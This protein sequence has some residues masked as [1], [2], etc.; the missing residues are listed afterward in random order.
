MTDFAF[1]V[2]GNRFKCAD[3]KF[4]YHP[5]PREDELLS[6]WLVRTSL[7]HQTDPTTFI[8]LYLPEWRNILWTRDIDISADKKFLDTLVVKTGVVYETCHNLTLMSYEGYLAEEITTKTRNHF[9]QPLGNQSRIKVKHGLRFC[10]KC[11]QEDESPYFR[12]KWRLSFSTACIKH[13]CFLMDRCAGCG[14]A[15]N[16]HRCIRIHNLGISHCYN[17]GADF[18]EAEPEYIQ[19]GSY[20]LWAIRRLYEILDTGLFT[21][22]DGYT[23]SFLFFDVLQ[24][25]VRIVYYWGKTRG[26]LDHEEMSKV[27]DFREQRLRNNLIENIPLKEQYLLFSGLMR[28]FEGYPGRLLSFC[29]ANRLRGS[30]MTRDMKYIPLWH[31]KIVDKFNMEEPRVSIEEVKSVILYLRERGNVVNKTAVG[32]LMGVYPDFKKR[33]DIRRLFL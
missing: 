2:K 7:N 13:K 12:K 21:Y 14:A 20:G 25:F 4:Q 28:L 3:I 26:F 6:S 22:K 31:K 15:V 19:E 33:E 23:Y 27:I 24:I 30:D 18:R 16:L 17:C 32:R 1:K 10:P 11:L 29:G 9:I 8:N 5:L